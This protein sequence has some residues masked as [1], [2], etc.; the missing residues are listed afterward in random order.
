[1]SIISPVP[2]EGYV[3]VHIPKALL[4]ILQQAPVYG[5]LTLEVVNNRVQKRFWFKE[6]RVIEDDEGEGESPKK[7]GG[8]HYTTYREN[9]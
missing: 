1:M 3:C 9:G 6:S 4:R 5:T 7:K 2:Q 8:K